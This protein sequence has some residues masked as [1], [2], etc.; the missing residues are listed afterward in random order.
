[1]F[2][3]SSGTSGFTLRAAVIAVALSLFLLASSTY[4][5]VKIGA[6]PWPIVFSVI[7]SGGIIKLLNRRRPVN[8]HEINVAQAGA[9]I[10]GLIAAGIAFT[11]PGILYLNQSQGLQID[12][13]NPWLLGLLTA[14][15]ALLGVLLSIPLKQT[16]IDQEQLP[17][18]AGTAGAESGCPRGRFAREHDRWCGERRATAPSTTS[19]H[20]LGSIARVVAHARGYGRTG[21]DIRR[22]FARAPKR[23][24]ESGFD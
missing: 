11:I 9:S 4:I 12:W 16:F 6:L 2:D 10:G 5:A 23:N 17:Y 8:I 21:R 20:Q 18:P 7:V 15:A 1:M 3:K 24:S 22:I 13:P 14:L 19:R